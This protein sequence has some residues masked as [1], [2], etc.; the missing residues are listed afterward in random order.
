M[1]RERKQQTREKKRETFVSQMQILY[2]RRWNTTQL[3]K[4]CLLCSFFS[5]SLL[6]KKYLVSLAKWCGRGL[7]GGNPLLSKK[8]TKTKSNTPMFG[9]TMLSTLSIS[10]TRE[11]N[12]YEPHI[13]K[14][15]LTYGYDTCMNFT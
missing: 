1:E 14:T 12:L 10:F 5:I 3:N 8:I 11:R 15:G 9:D 4:F 7:N 13:L 2:F 6:R